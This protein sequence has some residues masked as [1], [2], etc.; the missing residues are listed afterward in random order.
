MNIEIDYREFAL[1]EL[2]KV[3]KPDIVTTNLLVGDIFIKEN[4]NILL[5]IERK[6]IP[7]FCSSITDGRYREQKERLQELTCEKLYIIEG[8]IN[9]DKRE[10]LQSSII[11]IMLRDHISVFRTDDLEETCKTIVS[12]F[13]KYNERTFER[14]VNTGIVMK[15]SDK[16][17]NSV[18]VNQLCCINGMSKTIALKIAEVYPSMNSLIGITV[19]S[20]KDIQVTLKRKVGL[21]LAQKV[22]ESFNTGKLL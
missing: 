1:I 3:Q 20:L 18:F 4:E 17:N 13:K 6:S 16:L 5:V 15:K 7:D 21:K 9:C 14:K 12:L 10:T 8:N 19:D 11:N 2:L 22:V